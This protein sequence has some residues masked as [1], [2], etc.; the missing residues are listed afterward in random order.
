MEPKGSLASS[1]QE[2]ATAPYTL[3]D[4]S[5]PQPLTLFSYLHPGYYCKKSMAQNV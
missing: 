5:S 2:P 1:S 3:Q 4:E